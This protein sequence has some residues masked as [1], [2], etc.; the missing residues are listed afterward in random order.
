MDEIAARSGVNKR[1][2]YA[3][4]G[5]KEGLYQAV[6]ETVYHRLSDCERFL[7]ERVGRERDVCAA[8]RRLVQNYFAFLRENPSYVRMVMWENLYE[9]RN[10]DRRGLGNVRDPIRK[11][12]RELLEEG[13]E[14]GVFRRD[15]D[16]EQVLMSLFACTFNYFS[17]LHTMSR[18]MQEDLG[19]E[20][21][22]Q[23]RAEHITE[24][25]LSYLT[26]GQ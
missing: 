9:A 22:I 20:G 16:D 14:E 5:G 8:F 24:L 2:I 13:K 11:G 6:L 12:F 7:T 1:M 18:V 21:A 17:N 23:A 15:A 25:L 10:F 4:F 3:Y 26:D 19:A